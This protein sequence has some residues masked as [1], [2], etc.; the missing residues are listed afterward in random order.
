MLQCCPGRKTSINAYADARFIAI[1]LLLAV[2]ISVVY[3][4]N[5]WVR[6]KNLERQGFISEEDDKKN[7]DGKSSGIYRPDKGY[8]PS[9]RR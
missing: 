2:V 3:S 8:A 5:Q 4:C 7:R 6:Q 1:L 9:G